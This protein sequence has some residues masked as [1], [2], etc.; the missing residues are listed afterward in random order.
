MLQLS[1]ISNSSSSRC[2]RCNSSSINSRQG[3]APTSLRLQELQSVDL[4]A[5]SLKP[6]QILV[7]PH[8]PHWSLKFRKEPMLP[9]WCPVSSNSNNR[10]S[11]MTI[12]KNGWSAHRES[13][14]LGERLWFSTL[15]KPWFIPNSSR[16]KTLILYFQL[17]SRDRFVRSISWSDQVYNLSSKEWAD[18][19]K[20]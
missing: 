5:D 3:A 18:T 15:M 16:L 14:I 6:S 13:R 9:K 12:T 11:Q 4:I 1:S 10:E 20:W 8:L 7:I 19:L 2:N 17:K